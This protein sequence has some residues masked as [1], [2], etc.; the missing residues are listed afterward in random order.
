MAIPTNTALLIAIDI[1]ALDELYPNVIRDM[2][3]YMLSFSEL[4]AGLRSPNTLTRWT[5]YVCLYQDNGLVAGMRQENDVCR[6]ITD[7]EGVTDY[8]DG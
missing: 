8:E 6:I 1:E 5:L 4:E 7:D 2:Q 3:H